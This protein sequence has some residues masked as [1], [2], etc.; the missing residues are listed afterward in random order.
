MLCTRAGVFELLVH[1]EWGVFFPLRKGI[2]FV[3]RI[4]RND[5]GR[6][7]R[8]TAL[9][10][11]NDCR[12]RSKCRSRLGAHTRAGVFEL[13]VHDEWGVFFPLRKGILFVQRIGRNNRGRGNRGTAL[14]STNDCRLRSKCRSRLGAH[15]SLDRARKGC[16][17]LL[18][19]IVMIGRDIVR[20]HQGSLIS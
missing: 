6:G 11:T 3:Q 4:G 13:L 16:I 7:N 5:R 19:G 1:D 14:G 17:C 12:L 2:L 15:T 10:S 20:G 18:A 9:G 8:G